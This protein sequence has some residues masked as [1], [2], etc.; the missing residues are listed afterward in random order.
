[1][2]ISIKKYLLL[3]CGITPL[4][5]LQ[6]GTVSTVLQPVAS[7]TQ[8][9]SEEVGIHELLTNFLASKDLDITTPSNT[10]I[11]LSVNDV[12]RFKNKET[13]GTLGSVNYSETQYPSE[14][15]YQNGAAASDN[16]ISLMQNGVAVGYTFLQMTR[17]GI[18][19]IT[20]KTSKRDPKTGFYVVNG[21]ANRTY[22]IQIK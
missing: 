19:T 4:A 16:A 10:P 1:M 18:L 6:V 2:K 13:I 5:A 21:N 17:P 22:Q 15:Q 7:T 14:Y 12:V 11:V 20:I 3:A 9:A 8:E